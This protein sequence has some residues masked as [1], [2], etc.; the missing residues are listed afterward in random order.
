MKSTNPCLQFGNT[1]L[2]LVCLGSLSFSQAAWEPAKGPLMTRWAKDV[3]S[4]NAHPEYPRPQMA[5]KEWLNLNGLWDYAV[6]AKAGAQPERSEGKILVPFP[7][8]SALSGVMKRVTETNRLWYRRTF[9]IP[10]RWAGHRVLLHFGAVDWEATVFMNGHELGVHRGGYD[11]FSFDVTDALKPSGDQMIAV[12]VFDPTDAGT[13]PRGK[14][15]RNPRGIWYTPTSGIWQTVWLEP[16]AQSHIESLRI[17]PDFDGQSVSIAATAFS[18]GG[19]LTLQASVG[20]GR[21]KVATGEVTVGGNQPG[22]VAPHVVLGIPKARAW[23]PVDPFLYDLKLTLL[24]NGKKVDEVASYFGLRKIALGRDEKGCTRLFLN[25]QPVFHFGPLDQGFWPDGLYTAPTDAALRYD[26]EVTRKLGMNAARKHVKIEP[27]RWYYWCDKLGLL[28][29]QDMPSGDRY[30]S[31]R[32]PDITRTQESGRQFEQEL[33]ALVEGRRNHPSIVIWVPYNEGWGQWDTPRIV[34]FIKK[35]DPTRLVINA[36]GWTDRGAGD[37]HDIHSYPGPVAPKPESIRAGVLGEFGGLGLP[38]RGHTWQAEKNWGYRSFTNAQ[39]L[40]QAYLGL[41]RKLRPLIGTHGLSAAIYTQTTDVEIE[42]NG[43]MTYDRALIKID[44]DQ[45]AAANRKVYLP[46]PPPP[47]VRPL[48]PTSQER[49]IEW[50]YT[51]SYDLAPL[52]ARIRD[53]LGPG[54]NTIAVHCHQTTGGQYIDVGLVDVI[55]AGE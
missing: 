10:S 27:D 20:I 23:S 53:A 54:E 5:R 28:V 42:V 14:Q 7:V 16:V 15:V 2:L 6:T 34:D 11:G 37:V 33:T 29:W 49:G 44:A 17:T 19:K 22:K 18:P 51:G 48:N 41:I 45:V 39:A 38:V 25:N 3:S 21:R 13:Q 43:L 26:I 1:L 46:P 52:D 24:L 40:T 9:R 31:G 47:V 30:I 50:R 4:K 55:E 36:S 12:G 8:E 32:D 35:L